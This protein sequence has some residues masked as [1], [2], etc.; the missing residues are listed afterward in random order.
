MKKIHTIGHSNLSLEDFISILVTHDIR[1]LVDVRATPYSKRFPH[2]SE[3]ILRAALQDKGIIYHW[4]GRQLGGRRETSNHSIH[5]ALPEDMRG[6]ADYMSTNEFERAAMQLVNMSDK[7]AT[8][9]MCAEKLPEHC[10]RSLIAD[11]LLLKGI[12]VM[13]ITSENP[14]YEHHLRPEARR[15]S[16]SLIYDQASN[17]EMDF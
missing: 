16:A 13:H 17:M 7:T 1:V 6:F 4:A 3:Q 10:H 5:I 2:F 11:Y 12:Q 15:E 9:I 8:A 14:S